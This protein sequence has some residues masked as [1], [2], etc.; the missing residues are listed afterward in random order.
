M[1]M[2]TRAIT[3]ALLFGS[4]VFFACGEQKSGAESTENVKGAKMQEQENS[5]AENSESQAWNEAC[6]VQGGEVNPNVPTVAHNGKAYGFCCRGCD[7]KFME[8]PA[9]YSMNLSADGTEFLSEEHS[10]H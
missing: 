4:M 8:D 9:K 10:T 5:T 7:E 1:K 3:L 6:P 2:K